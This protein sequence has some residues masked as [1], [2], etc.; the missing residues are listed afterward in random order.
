MFT[1]WISDL[2]F[3]GFI[4]EKNIFHSFINDKKNIFTEVISEIWLICSNLFFL[5]R[6]YVIDRK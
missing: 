2:L 4:S 5:F 6:E 3:H 1:D